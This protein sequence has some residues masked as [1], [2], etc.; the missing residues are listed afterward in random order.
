MSQHKYAEI[1]DTVYFWFAVNSTAGEADDGAT[2]TY[3][4]RLAG[5][6]AGAAPVEGP[7]AATLLTEGTYYAGLHEIAYDTTGDAAGEYAVFCTAVVSTV[8]P[9]GFCGSYTLRTAGTAI[10]PVNTI[11]ISGSVPA[12]DDLEKIFTGG[13]VTGDV[14]ITMR[15]L[16]AICDTGTPVVIQSAGNNGHGIQLSGYGSGE[17]LS[18][19]GGATGAGAEFLGGS[20]SGA[21][22]RAEAR[23]GDDAGM[24]LVGEGT[25]PDLD[26]DNL[27]YLAGLDTGVAA[28]L[29]LTTYVPDGS[30]I[31]HMMT[32]GADTSTYAASTDSMQSNRDAITAGADAIFVSNAGAITDGTMIENGGDDDYQDLSAD[33]GTRWLVQMDSDDDTNI[34]ITVDFDLGSSRIAT[35]VII[36]GFFDA[37]G[38]RACQVYAYNYTTTSWDKLSSPGAATE[39][40]NA[41]ADV[42]YE[43]A[44]NT[45]H[46]KPTATVGEVKIR[47]YTDGDASDEDDLYL[48]YVAVTGASTGGASPQAIAQAVHTELDGHLTHI[49]CFTGEIRYVSKSGSDGNSGHM[50]DQA[51]LTVAAAITA[52]SAGDMIKIKSGAYDENGL[53]LGVAGLELHCEAGT[54]LQNSTPG[55]VLTVSANSCIVNTLLIEPTADQIGLLVSSN[56]N[57]ITDVYPRSAGATMFSVTGEHNVFEKCRADNYTVTGYNIANEE[58][59]FD[60]CIANGAGGATRGFYLSHTNTHDCLLNGCVSNNNDTA[61]FEFVAGADN[62]TAQN[63][64]SNAETNPTVNAGAGNTV[65]VNSVSTVITNIA[66]AQTELDKI[67]TIPALDGGAQTIGA[68][69]AKIADDNNGATYNAGEDSLNKIRDDRTIAAADY[70]VVGDTIAG[71]TVAG[72]VSGNV[73]GDVSGNVDGTVAGVTPEAAGVAPT[74]AEVV[75]EFE[76]QSQA[77]PTGFHVNLKEINDVATNLD[78]LIDADTTVAADADLTG[79]VVDGSVMSHVMTVGADTSTYNASTESQE[80]IRNRGDA[81][82]TT[83][84]GG[85]DRLLMVDTTI[86]TLDT[87]V[88]FTLTGGSADDDAYNNCTIVIQ[89]ATTAAQKAVG[90]ISAYTG[91]TKTVTLKYDPAVFVMAPTDKVYVLAEN[92]LKTTAANR[93]LDVTATGAA[94][95]DWANVENPTTAVDLSATDIQLCDTTTT[96]TNE[97]TADAVKISGSSDAAD[98]LEASAETIVVG[99]V[100]HDNTASSTTVF[101]SDDITEATADHYNGRIIIFTSGDLIRQ[102]T[103]ITDY[104]LDTGEGKFTVTALTEAPAD[105]VTF[106]IV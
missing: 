64:T 92:A 105:N 8:N 69:I 1:A 77:D 27:A 94:G 11:A 102:A 5:A 46:T 83:G 43:F 76:T 48:D 96:V 23:D 35:S 62:N 72:S 18:A 2:P 99:T 104:A 63:C 51:L 19:T 101:Y 3:V 90:V 84:A 36:N 89:D 24:E 45:S 70:V 59:I 88:S 65:G 32:T 6:A 80:G 79:V 95:I 97:V 28:D 26:A 42:D 47:F 17:G 40:R 66:T 9:A 56:F 37:G 10:M 58:N 75:N 81:E 100:S 60:Q 86:A 4:V 14:D 61:G 15:T 103:D 85:S 25:G 49:P 16:T 39:M 34:D 71:V 98:K 67:G 7:T 21:G 20:T 57:R 31:S 82:W 55:T 22:I 74:A 13:G 87:Q 33:D 68:A 106:V 41:G 53:D 91:A 29:D 50:P 54:I 12:A 78:K 73:D 44:L 52:S 93:Q 30:I 38:T